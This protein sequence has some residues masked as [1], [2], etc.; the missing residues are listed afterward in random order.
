[1]RLEAIA[2]QLADVAFVRRLIVLT[3]I[4]STNDEARRQ[5][6][7]GAPEGTVVIAAAQRAGRGRLGRGWHSPVGLGMYVS[8]VCRPG[9]ALDDLLRFNLAAA[10]ALCETC[11][12]AGGVAAAIKWPNDVEFAGRKLGGV[13][14]ESRT[15]G[16][17]VVDLILG[18]GL[19]V[20]HAPDDF[21]LELAPRA[22]SLRQ[23]L[24]GPP[25]PIEE[26]IPAYLR[27]LAPW[28]DAP[29]PRPWE[30]LARRWEAL[31]PGGR[32]QSIW[33]RDGHGRTPGV[34]EGLDPSG[35][36]RLRLA[37]GTVRVTRLTDSI[38]PQGG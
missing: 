11:R 17:R 37:D 5:A 16:D 4:D 25:P 32:G 29:E 9:P 36:L 7:D 10:V 2:T 27:A 19:N 12:A 1:M 15:T 26:L 24:G 30:M 31:A 14:A 35:G 8:V 21:P 38:T 18:A 34:T 13:L 6:A 20:G 28:F 33:L 23:A 22:T 3:E